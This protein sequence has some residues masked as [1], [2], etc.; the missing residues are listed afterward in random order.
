MEYSYLSLGRQNVRSNGDAD[1]TRYLTVRMNQCSSTFGFSRDQL[2]EP[3]HAISPELVS[4]AFFARHGAP[5]LLEGGLVTLPL[6]P[7]VP[8]LLSGVVTPDRVQSTSVAGC[9]D[10]RAVLIERTRC[11]PWGS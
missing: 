6:H 2:Q 8:P 7:I 4:T 1:V 3:S 5:S 9:F 11:K 10:L